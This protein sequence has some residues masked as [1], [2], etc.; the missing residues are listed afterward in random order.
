MKLIQGDLFAALPSD[1]KIIIP[2][3]CN[4]IGAFSAGFVVPLSKTWPRTK[5]EYYKKKKLDA[6]RLGEVQFIKVEENIVVANMI[7]QDDLIGP[8]N[9]VPLKYDALE[10]C[11]ER[12]ANYAITFAP[13][14]LME[15]HAPKFGTERAGGQW[16]QIEPII[17]R[18]LGG[19]PITIYYL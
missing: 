8:N 3:V 14:G 5:T 1:K 4:N 6:L 7:A 10:K 13:D 12:V 17:L 18:H 2:H 11:I 9:L 15:I 19:Y 16:S